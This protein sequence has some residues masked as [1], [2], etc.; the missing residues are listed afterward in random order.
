MLFLAVL[1]R[2]EARS[3]VSEAVDALRLEELRA[4]EDCRERPNDKCPFAYLA[5]RN[6]LLLTRVRIRWLIEVQEEL[7]KSAGC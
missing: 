6:A 7:C 2:G 1:P 3:F 4:K 5:A